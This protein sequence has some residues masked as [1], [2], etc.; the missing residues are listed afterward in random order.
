[1]KKVGILSFSDGRK[2]VHDGLKDYIK[3]CELKLF[4][5]LKEAD[6]I[7]IF[8]AREIIWN[9][10]VLRSCCDDLRQ[11]NVDALVFNIP[12]FAFPNLVLLAAKQLNKPI[13][14]FSPENGKLPGLGGM[15]AAANMLEQNGIRC[16][17]V[18]GNIE[19]GES[20]NS[21]L[22]FLRAAHVSN[23]LNGQIFGLIG[24]RSIGMGTGTVSPELWMQYFGVDVDHVDQSEILRQ[25]PMVEEKK[26]E[27]AFEWLKKMTGAIYFDSDKLT[28]KSLKDQ[29]RHY[30]AIKEIISEH[31]FDFV[32]VKCHYELSEYSNT[33]CLAAA[34]MND[35]YDWDGAK[36]PVVYSCEADADGAMT[37][38]IL[39]LMT[40]L[41][42]LFMDFR[43]FDRL[44]N[45]FVFCNCGAMATWYANRSNNPAENLKDVSLYPVIPKYGGCGAHVQYM[46]KEGIYTLARLSRIR[47]TYKMIIM[48]GEAV[49]FPKEKMEETCI[50][51]PHCFI[52]VRENPHE[53]IKRYNSNHIHAVYGD[54]T[55]ALKEFCELKGIEYEVIV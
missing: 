20:F 2:R 52:R 40:G 19:S 29:V 26:A 47:N 53:I 25:A 35:P 11:Y 39:H 44:N 49:E 51:W 4:G 12:V 50:Q 24:G 15:L 32:G 7:D 14:V 3:Q 18:W 42:V 6:D 30:Y 9:A 8:V 41:P 23:T 54:Y 48:Q 34:F 36:K 45:V 46:A 13:L 28:E 22:N 5:A 10:E 1:M 17:R 27:A 16:K 43:H 38:Q 31:K 33:Q 21:I 37:M 55:D